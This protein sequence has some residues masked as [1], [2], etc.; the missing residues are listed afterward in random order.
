MLGP[1]QA[2]QIHRPQL[3]L[4]ALRLAQPRPPRRPLRTRLLRQILEK[5]IARHRCLPQWPLSKGITTPPH[6]QP[7]LAEIPKESQALRN[8]AKQRDSNEGPPAQVRPPPRRRLEGPGT[9][10]PRLPWSPKGRTASGA[11]QQDR[12]STRL[13]SSH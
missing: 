1:D 13:N 9:V 4:V 2:V 6:E 7:K 5:P 12:K 11:A 10:R 3:D 8:A